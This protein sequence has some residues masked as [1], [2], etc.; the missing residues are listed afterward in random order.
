MAKGEALKEACRFLSSSAGPHC[1]WRPCTPP[2]SGLVK[3]TQSESE[4]EFAF[5]M[6]AVVPW[7]ARGPAGG[8]HTVPRRGSASLPSWSCPF[9]GGVDLR[10]PICPPHFLAW[11]R[12]ES[13]HEAGRE[14]RLLQRNINAKQG[15]CCL[16]L[17]LDRAWP[18]LLKVT[19][20]LYQGFEII[21]G[22][23]CQV[24]HLEKA[25]MENPLG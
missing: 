8:G 17:P 1:T 22:D 7:L 21:E 5:M 23:M 12:P 15:D 14:G 3:W 18:N 9:P 11:R 10:H 16:G 2:S 13:V 25:G 20:C 4:P 6:V 24:C 19:D